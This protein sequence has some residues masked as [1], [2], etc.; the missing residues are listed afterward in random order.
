MVSRVDSK[1][2]ST[3][4]ASESLPRGT[5]VDDRVL[6]V[7]AVGEVLISRRLHHANTGEEDGPATIGVALPASAGWENRRKVSEQIL[8]R[9]QVRKVD[10]AERVE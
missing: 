1:R 3:V 6:R 8:K 9:S 5:H 4:L 2:R 7:D 10:P